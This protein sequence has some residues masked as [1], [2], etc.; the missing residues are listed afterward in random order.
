M[1][2]TV[3][4]LHTFCPRHTDT[5]K[6]QTQHTKTQTDKHYSCRKTHY[7]QTAHYTLKHTHYR[8]RPTHTNTLRHTHTLI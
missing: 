1:V 4:Q 6:L 3:L 2:A 8:H 7:T 5:Y